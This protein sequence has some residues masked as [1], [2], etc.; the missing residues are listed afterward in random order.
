MWGAQFSI[1]SIS[2]HQGRE[3][4]RESQ[5]GTTSSW[6][7]GSSKRSLEQQP[8][9]LMMFITHSDW[10]HVPEMIRS[11]VSSEKENERSLL[12]AW[13]GGSGGGDEED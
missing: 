10:N 6:R 5:L 1:L 4:E 8:P 12:T 7:Y 3:R 13:A 2:D 11:F 9:R